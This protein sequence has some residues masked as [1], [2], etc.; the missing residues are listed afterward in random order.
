MFCD[1]WECVGIWFGSGGG[2]AWVQAVITA[3][4]F[5]W[6]IVSFRKGQIW[7]QEIHKRELDESRLREAAAVDRQE[8]AEKRDASRNMTRAK[9][10]LLACYK[11]MN[12]IRNDLPESETKGFKSEMQARAAGNL[13]FKQADSLF[14]L[15]QLEYPETDFYEL[16][17]RCQINASGAAEW[18]REIAGQGGGGT[19][20]QF[21]PFVNTAKVLSDEAEELIKKFNYVEPVSLQEHD[22]A[23][24]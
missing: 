20:Y 1:S 19:K 14:Y 18:L 5:W 7:A 15:S 6:S 12:N 3:A 23:A 2:A 9:L 13:V 21:Q 4:V 11:L 24:P 17:N 22:Y 10:S 16:I 8:A